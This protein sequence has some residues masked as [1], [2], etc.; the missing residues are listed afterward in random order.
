MKNIFLLSLIFL[1]FS[2][3]SS[4]M[5]QNQKKL[6]AYGFAV[7]NIKERIKDPNSIEIPS[8]TEKVNHVK[9]KGTDK[10][11]FEINSWFRSKNSFGGMVRSEFS[12]EVTIKD[13]GSSISGKNLKIK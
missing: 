12:C 7:D 2:C 5:S 10:N 13:N 6:L 11:T 4:E 8:I 1:F 3:G 9:Q